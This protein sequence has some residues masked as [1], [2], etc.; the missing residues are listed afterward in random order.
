[1]LVGAQEQQIGMT[2]S[3]HTAMNI[4][5]GEKGCQ[6]ELTGLESV[7]GGLRRPSLPSRIRRGPSRSR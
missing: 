1:V 3:G 4:K 2:G 5:G 6:I 7:Q